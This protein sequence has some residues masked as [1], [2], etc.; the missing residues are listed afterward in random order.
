MTR[1]IASWTAG[2]AP[3]LRLV[4]WA[5]AR[6]VARSRLAFRASDCHVSQHP[7]SRADAGDRLQL[8][9]AGP[10]RV[11]TPPVVENARIP[12]RTAGGVETIQV[13]WWAPGKLLSVSTRRSGA[14]SGF[15]VVA[16]MLHAWCGEMCQRASDQAK[17]VWAILGLNQ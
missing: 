12:L 13:A 8:S 15:S 5:V 10:G 2:L 11:L 17:Q 9:E 4:L 3:I 7:A 16:R 6:I 14:L 1:S